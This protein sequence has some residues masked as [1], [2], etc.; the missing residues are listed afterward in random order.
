MRLMTTPERAIGHVFVLLV[1]VELEA[2]DGPGL[3]AAYEA[4]FGKVED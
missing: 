3:I 4:R 2:Y 1:D